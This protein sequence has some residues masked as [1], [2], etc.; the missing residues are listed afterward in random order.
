M[1]GRDGEYYNTVISCPPT[2]LTQQAH[3]N[4]MFLNNERHWRGFST[5][6]KN[7]HPRLPVP[8]VVGTVNL[9]NYISD[10]YIIIICIIACKFFKL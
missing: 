7:K 10:Q 5:G 6:D 1:N 3:P 9:K 4:N 2:K 8:A